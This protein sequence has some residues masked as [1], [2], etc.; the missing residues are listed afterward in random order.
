MLFRN[1]LLARRGSKQ[2]PFLSHQY[3]LVNLIPGAG[4][5]LPIAS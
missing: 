5:C 2:P 1:V 4:T 3:F